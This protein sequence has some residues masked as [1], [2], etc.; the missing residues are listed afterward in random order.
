ML[1]VFDACSDLKG[2]LSGTEL[3]N[4]QKRLSLNC[5]FQEIHEQSKP[6]EMTETKGLSTQR[7]NLDL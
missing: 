6:V 4:E 5:T 3:K 1:K 2:H 7:I